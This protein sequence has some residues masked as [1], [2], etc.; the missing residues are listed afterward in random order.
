MSSIFFFICLATNYAVCQHKDILERHLPDNLKL[1]IAK[2]IEN[3]L[4]SKVVH[5]KPLTI[6]A[7]VLH[8]GVSLPQVPFLSTMHCVGNIR[9]LFSAEVSRF[10]MN[11]TIGVIELVVWYFNS[12]PL[13]STR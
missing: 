7:F 2:R 12:P 11:Q 5:F 8:H 9:T 13:E 1:T 3:N 10:I 6:F 4:F